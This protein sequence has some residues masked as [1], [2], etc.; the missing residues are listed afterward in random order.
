MNPQQKPNDPIKHVVLLMFENHSFDQMLGCLKQ[1]YPGLDGI[2]PARPNVNRDAEGHEFPQL[3]TR[4]RQMILDPRHE[5]NHVAVQMQDHNGGFVKDFIAANKDDK[6]LSKTVLDKQC[7]YIMGHYPLGFLPALHRLAREFLVCDHWHSSVP[8]P[9]WPNR[10][11]ALTGTSQGRV[12]M[13]ED[14]EHTV[15]FNGW[16]QQDQTTLFD[17]LS[18]QG[19]S[20]KVYFHDIPQ[21]VCLNHQRLPENAAR[22]FP[23]SAFLADALG[24]EVEFPAFSLIEPDYNGVTENDD[25]PPHD[26]MKAQKLLADVYNAIRSN[27]QLWNSTLLVVLHDEHGGFYDHVEPPAT[28]PPD[29]HQEEFTFDRLG[30]RVPAILVSP[31]VTQGFDSTPFDHT[32]LLAYLIEKWKLGPLGRRT[33]QAKSI[34]PLL[35]N[36][37]PRRDTLSWIEL[38][39]DELRPPDPDLEEDAAAYLSGHHRALALIGQYLKAELDE[40]LPRFYVWCARLC[41]AVR[42]LFV[43]KATTPGAILQNYQAAKT[44]CL[45]F[46]DRRKTKA[47][48]KLATMIRNSELPEH[49]RKHAAETLGFVVN[50][51]LHR[52]LDPASAAQHWLQRH[53]Q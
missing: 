11:F 2:D 43:G 38:S 3:E 41:I 4:E 32:S 8:G 21:T 30:I 18:E 15:D 17:R 39:P 20:W 16:F 26:I 9:T 1:V 14:G 33:A 10:F 27:N 13:P 44:Q 12:N 34:G 46:L 22:Y 6:G 29:D 7:R 28:V 35:H 5:V 51:R 24:P 49:V 52:E 37:P 25:H 48:P 31:W 36:G 50:R 19:I 53:G 45:T 47:L 23:I 40:D 42:R